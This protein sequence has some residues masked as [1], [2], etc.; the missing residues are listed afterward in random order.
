MLEHRAQSLHDAI[1][2]AGGEQSSLIT[3]YWI[4]EILYAQKKYL[5]AID[6]FSR[7]FDISP[8][9]DKAAIALYKR[10][11]ALAEMGRRDEALAQLNA[12]VKA[13]PKRQESEMAKQRLQELR[14]TKA[15]DP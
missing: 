2:R 7:V 3:Q 1:N 9:G 11:L 14:Q 4:G 13:Y 15:T 10:A 12:L 8:K 6:A 5:D